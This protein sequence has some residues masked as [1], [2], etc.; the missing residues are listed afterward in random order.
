MV[1]Y[2][3]EENSVFCPLWSLYESLGF[4]RAGVVTIG[5]YDAALFEKDV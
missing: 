5:E 3:I 4:M 2:S 1:Y